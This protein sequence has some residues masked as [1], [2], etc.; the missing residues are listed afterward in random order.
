M[1]NK[2]FIH[3]YRS[4]NNYYFYDVNK[5]TLAPINKEIYNYLND[6]IK[7]DELNS[8]DKDY[9]STLKEEGFLSD[10]RVS[11]I[12]H[13]MT[14]CLSELVKKRCEQM[15]LQVTQS[16][17]LICSYCPYAC[18]S[19][20]DLQR[21]HSNKKMT[22]E[23]AKKAIDLYAENT[24]GRNNMNISFYGGEPLI[25][26]DIIKKSVEYAEELF[27]GK[28]L[29]F[30]LTTNATLLTDEMIHFFRDHR[31]SLCFSLD[32]PK[33]IHDINR[34]RVDNTG[35]FDAT[36]SNLKKVAEIYGEELLNKIETNTVLNPA[37]DFDEVLTIFNDE[38]FKKYPIRHL[39]SIA[40]D[41]Y[42]DKKIEITDDFYSKYQYLY[43]KAML[44]EFSIVDCLDTHLIDSTVKALRV[45]YNM[46]KNGNSPLP[47][48]CSPG[49]PC[50]AGMKK[51][52]VDVEE[53][54]YPCERTSEVSGC[55]KI[56][57]LDGN[58]DIEKAGKLL[59]VAQLTAQK[60]KNCYAL[61]HCD[62]CAEKADD[63]HDLSAEKRLSN[64]SKTKSGFDFFIENCIAIKESRTYYKWREK[65]EV[66]DLSMFK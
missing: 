45:E 42:L 29:S 26:F 9:I 11:V 8:D 63:G 43:F 21:S 39:F 15:V 22:W 30:N 7:Y 54:I 48:I 14:D 27:L 18:Q 28:D 16:C 2:P 4:P 35:S 24:A 32:G 37:N 38:F 58:I 17:N 62:Q 25:A 1:E 50:I 47:E 44:K 12:R 49:G 61:R 13:T 51:I 36:F 55:M 34:K 66:L 60:C 59:N 46:L 19:N 41:G 3:L 5:D 40:Y 65:N 6:K 53:N 33:S 31:F 23:T 52:F 10:N 56:G 20:N 57:T 64:C